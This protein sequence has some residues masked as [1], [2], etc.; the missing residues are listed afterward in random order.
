VP[1]KPVESQT[2]NTW[3]RLGP[4]WGWEQKRFEFTNLGMATGVACNML[5]KRFNWFQPRPRLFKNLKK[6]KNE[7]NYLIRLGGSDHKNKYLRT[8]H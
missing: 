2:G 1:E 6:N 7:F 5:Q 4:C 8:N 3:P